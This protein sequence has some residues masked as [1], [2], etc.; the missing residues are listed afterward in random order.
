M[1][2]PALSVDTDDAQDNLRVLADIGVVIVL[3]EFGGAADIAY[4]ED[5][6]VHMV[7]IAHPLTQRVTQPPG[8][9]S[10]V[11]GVVPVMLEQVHACGATVIARGI[12]TPDD[13]DWWRS[14]GA[15]VGQGMFYALPGPPDQIAALLES[16]RSASITSTNRP[17]PRP[18]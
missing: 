3:L 4:A 11:A 7:D 16:A 10:R 9:R 13:A 8:A 5:L 2:I 17:I 1:P 6:P 12:Q 14:A 18:K 15:D